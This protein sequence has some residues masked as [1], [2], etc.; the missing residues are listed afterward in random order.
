MLCWAVKLSIFNFFFFG[1]GGEAT[2]L[3]SSQLKFKNWRICVDPVVKCVVDS[4]I[5]CFSLKCFSKLFPPK[6]FH[7]LPQNSTDI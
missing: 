1:G 6:I 4:F 2:L 3:S 7:N 5:I